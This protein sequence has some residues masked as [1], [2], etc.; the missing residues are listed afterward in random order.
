MT[1]SIEFGYNFGRVL[2]LSP[3]PDAGDLGKGRFGA[4]LVDDGALTPGNVEANPNKSM[5]IRPQRAHDHGM[6]VLMSRPT[7]L[8]VRTSL[9]S[10]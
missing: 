1:G 10:W 7:N 3:V 5:A 2:I 4:T 6:P 8:P 9:P